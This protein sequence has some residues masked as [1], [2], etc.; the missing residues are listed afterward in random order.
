MPAAAAMAGGDDGCITDWSIAAP[1]VSSEGLAT[2]EAVT[3]AARGHV[4]GD[5]VKLTLCREGGV[6]IY[7][8]LVRTPAG[9]HRTIR[10]DAKDPFKDR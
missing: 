6:Y 3:E 9:Q 4:E 8:L 10:T 2:V 5:I 7:R 1:I